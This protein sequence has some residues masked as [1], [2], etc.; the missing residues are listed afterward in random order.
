MV[1]IKITGPGLV[2][3]TPTAVIFK[4]L[5]DAGYEVDLETFDGQHQYVKPE[6]WP[7]KQLSDSRQTGMEVKIRVDPQPWGG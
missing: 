1:T 4:A 2:V 6:E 3:N 5:T 7:D